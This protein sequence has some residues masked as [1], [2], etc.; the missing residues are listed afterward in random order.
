MRYNPTIPY[1]DLP[2]LPPAEQLESVPVLKALIGA[3]KA[4]AELKGSVMRLPNPNVLLDSITL[5]EA[6]DSSEIENI[7]TTNDELFQ[8]I[9]S[10]EK[11]SNPATKEVIRYKTA[12]WEGYHT[13]KSTGILTTNLF[14]KLAQIIKQNQAGIR[15]TPGTQI[16]NQ[17]TQEVVFTP[18]TG[19]DIIRQKLANLEQYLH[20]EDD[21]DPLVKMAVS[22]YQFEAIHPFIDGNGRTGRI[23]NILYLIQQELLPIPI[24]YLSKYILENRRRYYDLLQEVSSYQNWERWILLMIRGIEYTSQLTCDKIEAINNEMMA[25]GE[26][27]RTALPKI[28]SKDLIEV[29]FSNPYSKRQFLINAGIA[30]EKTAGRYLSELEEKGFLT[31]TMVGRE[32]LYL[33]KT[34]LDILKQ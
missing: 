8:L 19:E 30:Q 25:T 7:I 29:L 3:H 12:L 27:L 10:S 26:R 24:L 22:H 33:N 15:N 14:I 4:L 6:K 21:T 20:S 18:P 32:R 9:A 17:S 16:V 1:N 31:S 23:I 34:L 5:Q 28:Y 2:N 13:L 11:E